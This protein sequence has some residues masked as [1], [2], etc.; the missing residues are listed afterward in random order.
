MNST[1]IEELVKNHIIKGVY[2]TTNFTEG[3]NVSSIAVGN[4]TSGNSSSSSSN[5]NSNSSLPVYN[6]TTITTANGYQMPISFDNCKFKC[7]CN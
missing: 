5:S 1:Q 6:L 2:Y 4:S 3:T 7:K